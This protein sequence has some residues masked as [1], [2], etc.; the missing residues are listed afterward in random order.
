M[1]IAM[2]HLIQLITLIFLTNSALAAEL[3]TITLT[4]KDGVFTPQTIEAPAQEKFKLIV[5]NEGTSAEEFESHELN[6][7]KVIA[8]GQSATIFLGPLPAG[9]YSFFGEFHPKT[10]QGKLIIK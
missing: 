9:S 7:E 10:A 2:K 1:E 4:C 3:K 6:R 5:K 8:P